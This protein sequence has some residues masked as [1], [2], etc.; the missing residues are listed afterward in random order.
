MDVMTD[1][2]PLFAF[3]RA[4]GSSLVDAAVYA[5]AGGGGA[6]IGGP[7]GLWEIVPDGSDWRVTRP[8]G[9]SATEGT[10]ASAVAA[11]KV[12]P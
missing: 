10:I 3:A 9:Q 6:R 12:L 4:L 8:D 1:L 7:A 2:G 11:A 5:A